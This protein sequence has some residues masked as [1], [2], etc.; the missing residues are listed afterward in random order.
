[1][2]AQQDSSVNYRS[3]FGNI[4]PLAK[5]F[6]HHMDKTN[7]INIIKQG[8]CY[9]INPI[10]EETRKSDLDTMLLRGNHK[11]FHLVLNSAALEKV[12]RKDI[13]HGWELPLTI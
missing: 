1:M 10:E 5:L 11:S 2:A 12:I 8:Y 9:H 4:V 6:L 13:D 7:I 3:E